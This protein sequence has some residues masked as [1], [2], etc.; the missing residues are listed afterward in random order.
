MFPSPHL[1]SQERHE[2]AAECNRKISTRMKRVSTIEKE[3][4]K[5]KERKIEKK[6]VDVYNS[7]EDWKEEK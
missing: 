2:F 1:K 3:K 6:Y 4:R 7:V 5:R